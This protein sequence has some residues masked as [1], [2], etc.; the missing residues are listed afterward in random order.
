MR[1][2]ALLTISWRWVATGRVG[3]GLGVGRLVQLVAS[4]GCGQAGCAARARS[5]G[6]VDRLVG[7]DGVVRWRA[8]FCV[9]V[10]HCDLGGR[11]LAP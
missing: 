2:V 7:W 11:A 6:V 4:D 9:Y 5:C 1:C 10:F 3:L 8:R